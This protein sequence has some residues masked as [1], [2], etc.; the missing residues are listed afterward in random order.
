MTQKAL[1]AMS[2]GVDSSVAAYLMQQRGYVC[3]G[4]TMRLYDGADL[5]LPQSEG[6]GS[7]HD[8]D[9]AQAVATSLGMPFTVFDCTHAFREKVIDPFVKSYLAGETPNPCIACNRYLKFSE[10]YAQARTMGADV[11]VTGHYA[12]VVP[13]PD[14]YVLKKG[15]DPTKDQSYVLYTLTQE[16]LAHTFFPLGELRKSEVRELA[17]QLGFDNAEK[18]DSQ[19]I[20][21]VPDGNY[22]DVVERVSG[23]AS[24]PGNFIDAEGRVLG[25]HRGIMHYTIGQRKG[26]GLAFPE[27]RYVCA[28]NATD[29]TVTI[30][31][32]DELNRWSLMACDFNW[33]S[34]VAP[35][36]PVRCAAKTRYRQV[37][38]PAWA[39]VC[40]DGT[41]EVTFD[42]PQQGI[43]P[44]QSVVLYDGD[45]VLGGGIIMGDSV[46]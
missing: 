23:Q 45:V 38:Q 40:G 43:A 26:L 35:S 6:C 4:C 10:L 27:P 20:C 42:E 16:Q 19:D 11:L 7:S 44:G 9:D 46:K 34:G 18:P 39:R 3:T 28:I 30:G 29:N 15:L 14:G 2:G 1:I 36:S 5:G 21:F 12:R 37:E 31:K 24:V 41:V 25:Q 13:T 33:M 17:A 32:I 8:A 22:A